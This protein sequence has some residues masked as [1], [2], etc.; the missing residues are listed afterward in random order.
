LVTAAS[1]LASVS[2]A[3]AQDLS[4]G[5]ASEKGT[6][7]GQAGGGMSQSATGASPAE[8]MGGHKAAEPRT[9]FRSGADGS[10]GSVATIDLSPDDIRVVQRVLIERHLL[11]GKADGVLGPETRE[12]VR[13]FQRRQGIQVTG[14]IDA[15]TVSSLGVSGRLSQ[16]ANQS[17]SQPQSSPTG[18]QTSTTGHERAGT[19][20]AQTSSP[21]PSQ[22]NASGQ[23]PDQ[24]TG[25]AT[26]P[27]AVQSQPST[28]G[29]STPLNQL[30]TTGQAAPWTRSGNKPI[31]NGNAPSGAISL[32][33]TGA[34][35]GFILLALGAFILVPAV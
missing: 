28:T 23:A 20:Q 34:A 18:I 24:T 9:H 33:F 14:S 22:Q 2:L 1:V 35:I 29:Q 13:A 21:Q 16:Q 32:S 31:A 19:G 11:H 17:N 25:L 4:G 15:R 27:P 10:S 5:A 7:A 3:S 30:T 26:N 6:S 8:A 12:A